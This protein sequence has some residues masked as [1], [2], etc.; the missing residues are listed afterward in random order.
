MSHPATP[1]LHCGKHSLRQKVALR[2]AT[3]DSHLLAGS[4]KITTT[5]SHLTYHHFPA[6]LGR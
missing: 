3:G 1:Q 2:F 4:V 5:C 6:M